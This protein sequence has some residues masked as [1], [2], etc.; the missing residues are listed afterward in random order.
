MTRDER[1]S[2]WAAR[3]AQ[4]WLIRILAF[5]APIAGSIA[6]VHFASRLVAVP[7][8]SFVLFIAWWFLMSAA[9]TVVLLAIDRVTRRLLPLAALCKL[10]LLFPDAAPS[11]FRHAMRSNTADTLAQRLA[12][13]SSDDVGS[14]PAEAA[15]RLLSLV[16]ELDRHDR[17]T[18]G[19]S[20]RVRAYSQ[21]IAAELHLGE[22]ER[23][24][25]NWAALL[26]DVG[27]LGVPAEILTKRG[28]PTDEEWMLLRRHTLIGEDLVAPLRAW[29]G[30]WSDAVGHHH[31][32]WAGD[33]YP[34]GFSGEEISLAGR[35]VAV[36]DVFDV[37]TS[38]RSYKEASASAFARQEIADGSG[39]QFDPLVVRAFLNI[40]LGR[41]R[42][43]MG[44]LSWLAHAPILGRLPL[45]PAIGTLS[46]SL[47]AVAAAV[48]TGLASP[49]TTVLASP[50]ASQTQTLLP[51]ITRVT[52]ENQTLVISADRRHVSPST[53]RMT[54]EPAVGRAR[55]T[56][57]LKLVYTPPPGY[58]GIVR[59]EYAACWSPHDCGH[60]AVVI[61]VVSVNDQPV[62]RDDAAQ[63]QPGTPVSIDVLANDSDA[64]G[65]EL[66]IAAVSAVSVGRAKITG[67]RI[68][69][70]PPDG[71]HGT[72][73]FVYTVT[74]GHGGAARG[75]VTVHVSRSAP[76]PPPPPPSLQQP[77][78]VPEPPASEPPSAQPPSAQPP[79]AHD[80]VASGPEGGTLTLDVLANDSDPVG[81]P[82]R[83]V[84]VGSPARGRAAVI[85]DRMQFVAPS[86]YVGHV[87]FSYTIAN[88]GGATASAT[89]DVTVLLVNVAPTFTSGSDQFVPE[90]AGAQSIPRF[91]TAISAGPSSESG[92]SVSF[93][94][95]T[96]N[97]ALFT[98]GGQPAID[99]NGT[100]TYT[101]A[102]NANGTATVTVRAKDDAG[103]ANGGNDTSIPHTTTITITAVN[104]PPVGVPDLAT[105]AEDDPAGVTFNVIANDT[106]LDTGDVLLVS[107]YDPS[108]IAIG[109]LAS[110][111]GGSFTYVPDPGFFGAESFTYTVSDG[112]GGSATATATIDV[113]P[114]QHP[115]AA[116]DDAYATQQD[117]PISVS[118]PGV[119]ANDGDQDGNTLTVETTLVVAPTNGSA[120]LAADG[121]FTYTPGSSFTGTDSFTYRID[122]GTG[123]SADGVATI[124]VS[125]V[126]PTF[127]TL[128]LQSTGSD[129]DV[130][131][132]IPTLQ[133]AAPQLTDFDADGNPGLTI[134]NSD[135]KDTIV[136]V[137]KYHAWAYPVP[138][139]L[140]LN[141]PVTLDLWSSTGTFDALRLGKL[142]TYLYDCTSGGLSCTPIATS[143]A[144]AN[145]WNAP[146]LDWTHRVITI[147]TLNRTIPTGNELRIKL[148]FHGTDLWTTMTASYASALVVTLG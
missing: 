132:M 68:L 59:V 146:L 100:L 14:T 86:N 44:P 10:S 148:L 99:P 42:L 33:G 28:K 23:E 69:W 78:V 89:V 45:T 54:G 82:L 56:S 128:Y 13:E 3:P 138:S 32:Y 67:N 93:L 30:E 75:Q 48:T 143:T 92:E 83:L 25:L 22:Q 139:P 117:T 108:S 95:S 115:P 144:V 16:G 20:E 119:L 96:T 8:S 112:K 134:K 94:T 72:T 70:G 47:A 55:V 76:P 91:A 5:T 43:V 64:D 122:D 38:A 145:P 31:E 133:P 37:I 137:R 120:T 123:R 15:E 51:T 113:T 73:T 58:H 53:L 29:L 125:A 9:A 97:T 17:L 71:Y 41:L 81:D 80:D 26:H 27:K 18:R 1:G 49:P 61:T 129:P 21:L 127:T 7:T 104:D 110:N 79:V 39:T 101:P 114:V 12:S 135:G 107:S 34:R 36:A 63:T 106:D 90:D 140:V 141:G 77:A 65:E 24:L 2:H 126:A 98:A 118:A 105:V 60:G 66:S 46:A 121:S 50:V 87:R 4:A 124:T 40:S 6:F 85:G 111:G 142:Y 57:G 52:N 131:D 84:S 11:R 102:P 147:G 109:A 74:D 19:H 103:T 35:I 130:W 88:S 136:D 62:A 116:G